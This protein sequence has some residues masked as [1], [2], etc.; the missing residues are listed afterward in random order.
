[1][2]TLPVRPLE[3]VAAEV[4]YPSKN[5]Q[6]SLRKGEYPFTVASRVLAEMGVRDKRSEKRRRD[7]K[8][9]E[10]KGRQGP[11]A[12]TGPEA[13]V[14]TGAAVTA[15][16]ADGGQAS[17]RGREHASEAAQA[18]GDALDERLGDDDAG[19][20]V[21]R[22]RDA[23]GQRVAGAAPAEGNGENA[24]AAEEV[25]LFDVSRAS[26]PQSGGVDVPL[27][28][29]E[30][31]RIDWKGKT[32]LAPL[33]TVGNLPFRRVCKA[34]GVDITIGEM[35]LATN[36]LQ[37]HAPEWALLRRHPSEDLFGVQ[38]CGGFPDAMCKVSEVVD[39]VCNVDFVDI[40]MGCPI[41]L[42]CNKGAGS[43]L[44]RDKD[45]SRMEKIVRGA[46]Q[47]LSCPLTF[48]IRR[49]FYENKDI[50]HEVVQKAASWGAEAVTLHGRTRQQR[51]SRLA[52][53]DYIRQC[54]AVSSVPLIGNGD[55]YSWRDA[56]EHLA[57][58]GLATVM[59][60]RG[61]LIKPWIFTEIKERRDWD[62]SGPERL[63]MLKDF[64]RFG[65]EHW[66]SDARGV[67]T[68]RRFLL[69][70]LSFLHRYVPVGLL[71]VLPPRMHL[72]PPAIYGRSQLETL[73]ASDNASDWVRISEML[74]GPVPSGFSFAPKHKTNSYVVSQTD[75]EALGG[76]TG[77]TEEGDEN[78]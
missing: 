20:V 8:G 15:G 1:V 56:E 60:A 16:D 76:Q 67:E 28:P 4:N 63:D 45:L 71:E 5:L 23:T 37:G 52:D 47:V 75:V 62:I 22:L 69:E 6:K 48:K 50:A 59:V 24:P 49:G 65:L 36:L 29:S 68:T 14:E 57:S 34:F 10:G 2:G 11:A 32:Y 18:A 64:V 25:K 21:K 43:A 73:L 17:K 13:G 53:W 7:G 39:E 38:I 3:T 9:A 66:G 40:N 26:M 70:W 31:R 44:L 35:A 78:G 55:V 41:D 19:L 72:R 42:I 61:G 58:G 12:A 54:A 74:L 46:S 30:K 77:A 33:T 27:R 51:Y